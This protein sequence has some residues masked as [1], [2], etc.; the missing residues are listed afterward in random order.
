MPAAKTARWK[1]LIPNES[2]TFPPKDGVR[3]CRTV[4][5][6][7]HIPAMNILCDFLTG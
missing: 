2:R 7:E 5:G 1:S 3:F 6:S 4:F